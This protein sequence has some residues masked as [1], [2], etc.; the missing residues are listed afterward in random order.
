MTERV[1]CA[2]LMVLGI[3]FKFGRELCLSL[4]CLRD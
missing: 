1:R 4:V 3:L 2:G